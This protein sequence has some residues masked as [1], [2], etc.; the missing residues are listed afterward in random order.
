[1]LR[2][3]VLF[4]FAEGTP[5][6]RID[7]YERDLYDYV[8]K[9]DGVRSYLIGRDAGVNPNTYDMSI[10]AEFADDAAF[11]VYFDGERHKEIQAD[12]AD[13]IVSK[14]GSQSRFD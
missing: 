5:I 13:M 1:M 12:T 2:H 8:A 6:E 7:A 4:K 14:A 10:V 9:L 3:V 11:R